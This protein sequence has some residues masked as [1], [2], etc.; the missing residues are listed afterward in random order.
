MVLIAKSGSAE[1]KPQVEEYG[2]GGL[3]ASADA[4]VAGLGPLA[5]MLA[6]L[7]G[8][9]ERLATLDAMEV[10]VAGQGRE[11]LPGCSSSA[12]TRRRGPRCGCR[13]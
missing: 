10:L 1:G 4:V 6:E 8:E 3:A 7:A 11:L 12:W 9:A 13:G 2:L 5:V